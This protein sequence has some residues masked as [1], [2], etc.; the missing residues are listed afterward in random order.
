MGPETVQRGQ[1]PLGQKSML[2]STCSG[3]RS[4][5]NGGK[6]VLRLQQLLLPGDADGHEACCLLP[7]DEQLDSSGGRG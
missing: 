3:R 1:V 4:R 7:P 2:T 6:A 5:S